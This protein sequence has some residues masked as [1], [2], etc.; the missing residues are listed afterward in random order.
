M[1]KTSENNPTTIRSYY[2]HLEE[3]NFMERSDHFNSFRKTSG[4]W[5][6]H[7]KG[8]LNWMNVLNICPT[9][10]RGTSEWFA[11]FPCL[12]E[13]WLGLLDSKCVSFL[14]FCLELM[15]TTLVKILMKSMGS[16][17][18]FTMVYWFTFCE[19]YFPNHCFL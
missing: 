3:Y 18:S 9:G 14:L 10:N 6:M 13:I 8:I 5:L 12:W 15:Y 7:L 1:F 2:P 16:C 17:L 4:T 11:Y 19:V